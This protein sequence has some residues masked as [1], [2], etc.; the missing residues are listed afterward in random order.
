ME[1]D[2]TGYVKILFEKKERFK[3]QKMEQKVLM[4][5]T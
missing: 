5:G 4:N 1:K 3:K 2:H